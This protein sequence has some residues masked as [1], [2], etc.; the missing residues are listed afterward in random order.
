MLIN[1]QLIW[2]E[3]DPA[4]FIAFPSFFTEDECL[5]FPIKEQYKSKFYVNPLHVA[6]IVIQSIKFDSMSTIEN[7]TEDVN[8][9]FQY[10]RTTTD[11]KMVLIQQGMENPNSII[12]TQTNQQ[13]SDIITNRQNPNTNTFIATTRTLNTFNSPTPQQ[14]VDTDTEEQPNGHLESEY[15]QPTVLLGSV[16]IIC[17]LD[18]WLLC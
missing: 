8:R 14:E 10:T 18:K 16:I 5:P 6:N 13:T 7:P 12:P 4:A 9:P 15:L 2:S 11:S 17:V 3:S 1:Y